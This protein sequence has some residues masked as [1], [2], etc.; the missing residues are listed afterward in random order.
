MNRHFTTLFLRRYITDFFF[1]GCIKGAVYVPPL[2]NTLPEFAER[3]RVAVAVGAVAVTPAVLTNRLR[4]P[5]L[6]TDMICAK[7]LVVPSLK[8]CK[9]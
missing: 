4:G 8:I 2:F 1:L 6:N 3:I 7:L 9:Q 5:N